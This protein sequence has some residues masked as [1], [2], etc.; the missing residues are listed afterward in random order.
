MDEVNR[1]EWA[2]T[3][4]GRDVYQAFFVHDDTISARQLLGKAAVR[5]P[6]ISLISRAFWGRGRVKL[7]QVRALFELE[8]IS[9]EEAQVKSF[10][11]LCEAVGVVLLNKRW[12][13]FT[14]AVQPDEPVPAD[15]YLLHPDT[16][17]SNRRCVVRLLS[18]LKGDV[19]W[20][21]KYFSA[22]G[23]DFIVAGVNPKCSTRVVIV[24]GPQ[25]VA[26]STQLYSLAKTELAARDVEL[27]WKVCR[28]NDV[29]PSWHDRWIIDDVST[30]NM[31]PVGSLVKGQYSQITKAS[32]VE[33][34]VQ[35]LLES[36]VL[37]EVPS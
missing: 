16:P 17:Y 26:R 32:T 36:S 12:Y 11:E 15:S 1:R 28:D 4:L 29:L 18:E 34:I 7:N 2:L 3:P 13:A 22:E 37:L 19:Y 10:L 31:P 21:D 14:V 6:V 27:Q 23:L 35:T 8:G 33:R 24:S 30:F 5:N 20:L 25:H 9:A